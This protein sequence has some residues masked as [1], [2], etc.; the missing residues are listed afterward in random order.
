WDKRG[1]F[2]WRYSEDRREGKHTYRSQID[3]DHDRHVALYH[4]GQSYPIPPHVQDALSSFYYTRYQALPI[5]GSVLFDYHASKRSQHAAPDRQRLIARVV[6]RRQGVL[7]VRR[8][9]IALP[10]VVERNVA[11]VV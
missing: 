4:N 9:R 8:D 5:G 10:V 7:H 3:F 11:V 6:E 2:S 1:R